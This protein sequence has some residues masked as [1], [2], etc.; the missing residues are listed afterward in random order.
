MA[1]QKSDPESLAG[2]VRIFGFGV[3]DQVDGEAVEDMT[4][5]FDL[6]EYAGKSLAS[7]VPV[8]DL[9]GGAES[10]KRW[11]LRPAETA[12]A[13]LPAAR[14]LETL[15]CITEGSAATAHRDIKPSNL[16]VLWPEEVAYGRIAD[17]LGQAA[18]PRH[19]LPL[20]RI[21]DLGT[22][23]SEGTHPG[24]TRTGTAPRSEFWS[25]PDTVRD[26]VGKVDPAADVWSFA[27]TL[28]FT[29]TGTFPWQELP[30]HVPADM[31]RF[32]TVT[33]Q[34]PD[35]P[36]FGEL[37]D[38]MAGLIRKCLRAVPSLRPSMDEVAAKLEHIVDAEG[39]FS[40]VDTPTRS[41][42]VAAQ[43]KGEQE[44]PI[45]TAV[46]DQIPSGPKSD[47]PLPRDPHVSKAAFAVIGLII[48]L[49]G[50]FVLAGYRVLPISG[51]PL[52]FRPALT[53]PDT[54]QPGISEKS[55]AVVAP[56][57]MY[58]GTDDR[59]FQIAKHGPGAEALVVT[60]SGDRNFKVESGDLLVN[61]TGNYS[62]TV[63]LDAPPAIP[64]NT[65]T[66]KVTADGPWTVTATSLQDLPRYD[67]SAP[68]TGTSDALFYYTGEATKATFTSTG[69]GNI[70]V[71]NY[72][73]VSDYPDFLVNA[74]GNYSGPVPWV[75]G[76]YE[77][78]ADGDWSATVK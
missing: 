75:R 77:V 36:A 5:Y 63:L 18:L 49:F 23:R 10:G 74:I 6:M 33:G 71:H 40:G 45:L 32:L 29:A 13:F 76:L 61:V 16:L 15:H 14:A 64:T 30:L 62:G 60:H 69:S 70:I 24:A 52:D 48:I 1:R 43:P 56:A 53:A 66:L 38:E 39:V 44:T 25:A 4:I 8:R 12:A 20:I 7:L 22:V 31:V 2:M 35:S 67:G 27:A 59:V 11:N 41:I 9:I 78:I 50:A 26:G 58:S 28:F 19:G 3:V 34:A 72:T 55:P 42:P 68:I 65:K 73:D 47:V 46:D 37:P 17:R 21:G 57:N 51:F 54:E